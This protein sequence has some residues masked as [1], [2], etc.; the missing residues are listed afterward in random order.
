MMDDFAIT[1]FDSLAQDF[2]TFLCSLRPCLLGANLQLGDIEAAASLMFYHP[3]IHETRH[4]DED[5]PRLIDS[6]TNLSDI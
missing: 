2:T 3:L 1:S 6:S 5:W 4:L